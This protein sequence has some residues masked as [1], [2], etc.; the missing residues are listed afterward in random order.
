[1]FPEES[2]HCMEWAKDKFDTLFTSDPKSFK[3][4][5]EELSINKD[6]IDNID[7]KILN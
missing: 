3:W 6:N 2:I 4:V 7:Y 1:M 5:L